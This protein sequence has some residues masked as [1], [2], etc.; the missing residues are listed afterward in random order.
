MLSSWVTNLCA[1]QGRDLVI[2]ANDVTFQSGSFGVKVR[3][4]EN[5][6]AEVRRRGIG[7]VTGRD[8]GFDPI[9]LGLPSPSPLQE[10]DFF[11]AASEY[12]RV[13]GLPR[14]Y[15]SSNSGARIGTSF[16]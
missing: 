1:D 13:R 3:P 16:A 12:A 11:R 5:A 9:S 14:I 6:L 4:L 7:H 2:I 8:R 15:L 10:D